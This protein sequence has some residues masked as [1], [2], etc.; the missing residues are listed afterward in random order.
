MFQRAISLGLFLVLSIGCTTMAQTPTASV[1]AP[2]VVY[3]RQ[4][5]PATIDAEF[6]DVPVFGVIGFPDRTLDGR[7]IVEDNDIRNPADDM[8]REIARAFALRHGYRFKEEGVQ[9][10]DI[11]LTMLKEKRL[12]AVFPG[13]TYV[14]SLNVGN[15]GLID[16]PQNGLNDPKKAGLIFM[17]LMFI[18]KLPDAADVGKSMCAYIGDKGTDVMTQ[19]QLL[20]NHAAGL[21]ALIRRKADQCVDK[22]KADL[23]L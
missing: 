1:D 7:R 9:I 11:K 20:A 14:V 22:M 4:S 2:L 18:Q 21:K 15:M 13:A 23:N 16:G 5:R 10:D 19:D 17:A 8:A 12:G 3:A 6:R